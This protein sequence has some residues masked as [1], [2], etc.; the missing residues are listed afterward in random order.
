MRVETRANVANDV[1]ATIV[2]LPAARPPKAQH[3]FF[4]PFDLRY[5]NPFATFRGRW[6]ELPRDGRRA[7]RL[8]LVAD[9][10]DAA[11]PV[12]C[13]G[14]ETLCALL[15]S[16]AIDR[17][18]LVAV[19]NSAAPGIFDFVASANQLDLRNFIVVALNARSAK[20]GRAASRR[21]RVRNDAVA[22]QHVVRAEVFHRER[23]PGE[24]RQQGLY[25]INPWRLHPPFLFRD[26]DV[27]SMWTA[28]TPAPAFGQFSGDG[29]RRQTWGS[30]KLRPPARKRV[31]RRRAQLIACG[32][33]W[34]RA[35]SL[36]IPK[37]SS[38][39]V[40]SPTCGTRPGGRERLELWFASRDDVRVSGATVRVLHP[41]CFVNSATIPGSS[42]RGRRRSRGGGRDTPVAMHGDAPR[43]AVQD[44][45]GGRRPTEST[46]RRRTS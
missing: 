23:V 8:D 34:P 10:T 1:D 18:V 43:Q 31:P 25:A 32:W 20:L 21:S 41:L 15:R 39:R 3:T 2:E 44:A 22:V 6:P 29:R 24:G 17:E 14:H 28:G 11:W 13:A 9:P 4:E 16:T 30:S 35:P 42:G 37:P 38:L 40:P 36:L 7:R 27:E 33:S 19:A 45:A 5:P 12:N 46:R 26:S